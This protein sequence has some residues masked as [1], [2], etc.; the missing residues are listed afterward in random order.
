MTSYDHRQQA[1]V[2]RPHETRC[3]RALEG[4]A[5]DRR[6]YTTAAVSRLTA[7]RTVHSAPLTYRYRAWDCTGPGPDDRMI[8]LL[9]QQ[10]PT[11]MRDAL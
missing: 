3:E 6:A 10:G 2:R 1:E 7:I 5:P 9:G 11:T 8:I 4:V